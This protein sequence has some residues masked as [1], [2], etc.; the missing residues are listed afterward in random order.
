MNQLYVFHIIR[1]VNYELRCHRFFG[2]VSHYART[3]MLG[4]L[5]LDYDGGPMTSGWGC[6]GGCKAIVKIQDDEWVFDQQ[7]KIL[8]IYDIRPRRVRNN[9]D[10]LPF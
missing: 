9:S 3:V 5:A 8:Q 7:C 10:I 2:T 6:I 4:P 1:R